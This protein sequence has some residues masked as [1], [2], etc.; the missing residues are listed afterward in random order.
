MAPNRRSLFKSGILFLAGIAITLCSQWLEIPLIFGIT[1]SFTTILLLLMIRYHGI[2]LGSLAAV[3]CYTVPWL[4]WD[5]PHYE[6]VVLLEVVCIGCW[7]TWSKKGH[8]LIGA[9]LYWIVIGIPLLTAAYMYTYGLTL[10]SEFWLMLGI[11]LANSLFNATFSDM[12]WRYMPAMVNLPANKEKFASI[13]EPLYFSKVLLHTILIAITLPF[14]FYMLTNSKNTYES[15]LQSSYQLASNAAH[16]IDKDL[17]NWDRRVASSPTDESLTAG[18]GLRE[19]KSEY[20]SNLYQVV[21]ADYQ[22]MVI[23]DSA[24]K[25]TKITE[26]IP[27]AKDN[28][29][30]DNY[31]LRLP[32]NNSKL[33][34]NLK[35]HD[36]NFI[37]SSQ[38][39]VYSV[40]LRL[41]VIVPMQPYQKQILNEFSEQ[42][43]YLVSF[44]LGA[45]LISRLLNMRMVEGLTKLASVSTDLSSQLQE[46]PEKDWPISRIFEIK[47][48][49]NNFRSLSIQLLRLLKDSENNYRLLQE[50]TLQL[51]ES[52]KQLHELAYYDELTGLPNR[53]H[54]HEFTKSLN[55]DH[56][57]SARPFAAM[58][59]DINR[60]KQFNDT[61]GHSFGDTLLHSVAERFKNI[62]SEECKVF[63]IS[64]DEFLFIL[65]YEDISEVQETA[66]QIC[67]LIDEPFEIEGRT[68]YTSLSLGISVFPYDGIDMGAVLR[69]ADIAMYVAKEQGG[70]HYHF[71]DE[72][73]EKERQESMRLENDLRNALHEDQ[74][75]LHYQP[76][77]HAISKKV[78]GA[79]A[80]IR[81]KHPELGF[82]S[83]AQFIPLAEN[84]G[85]ILE[86]DEWVL[87]EACRQNK[88]WQDAGLPKFPIAVNLS[89]R[90]FYQNDLIPMIKR[91]LE[92]TQIE[93]QYI[94]LEITEGTFIKDVDFGV[95]IM[96]DLRTMGIHLSIDDFGTGYSSLSQLERLPISEMKLDRSFIQGL[97]EDNRKSSIV[98]TVIELGHHMKLKV[99]A[100]G[101]ESPQELQYLTDLD[102]DE[103]Q[104]YYFSKP[105]PSKEFTSFVQYWNGVELPR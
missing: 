104:G 19:L 55:L 91:I 75:V 8:A 58:F 18:N 46:V 89:A 29:I 27:T 17:L 88:A 42:F 53:I 1:L 82:V 95:Q 9:V 36:A 76:K 30:K 85:I 59:A 102:C 12:I 63:R 87:R 3:I 24:S 67:R 57:D 11:Y 14:V 48:L 94:V 39:S 86:I 77:V 41:Y 83:P 99:V 96:R 70:G 7:M 81:W 92:D 98:K 84:T 5:A 101:V 35:W 68:L 60:F 64:G 72:L 61:L 97:M 52:E 32:S 38:T 66:Q 23:F 50:Q 105:L 43:A 90:H 80:L 34:P 51:Q 45:A 28:I 13:R 71:Y 31:F 69:N 37:Y 49:V 103:F 44:M 21:L 33:L 54:F 6:M 78:I 56:P 25:A 93:P 16:H 4:Y 15:L 26:L 65:H 2:V 73:M 100:E 79:E 40:P 62:I 74:F 20:S 10:S 22:G 47:T